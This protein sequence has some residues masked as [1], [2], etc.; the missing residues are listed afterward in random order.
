M[1]KKKI[2]IAVIL[3]GVVGIPVCFWQAGEYEKTAKLLNWAIKM[4]RDCVRGNEQSCI[5]APAT[6]ETLEYYMSKLIYPLPDRIRA[7][8]GYHK[9]QDLKQQAADKAAKADQKL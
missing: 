9:L 3:F 5:Q 1:N 6:N 4:N 2:L 8:E 7:S